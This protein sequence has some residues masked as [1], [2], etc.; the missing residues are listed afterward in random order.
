MLFIADARRGDQKFC[1][2]Q[3]E[4]QIPMCAMGQLNRLETTFHHV[5]KLS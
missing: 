2:L 4:G 1:W 3:A 5:L